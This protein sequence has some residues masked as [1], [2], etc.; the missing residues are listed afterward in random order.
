VSVG[1]A[2][3][4]VGVG[5]SVEGTGVSV[6]GTDVWVG[7]TVGAEVGMGV[8]VSVG[9]SVGELVGAGL[10]V[11]VGGRCVGVGEAV[12]S[13]DVGCAAMNAEVGET[14]LGGDAASLQPSNSNITNDRPNTR[15]RYILGYICLL[16]HRFSRHSHANSTLRRSA[17]EYIT[18]DVQ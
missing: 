13:L 8:D 4:K 1:G 2:G 16:T 9:V 10:G 3:E 11:S 5:V 15:S 18:A 14:E 17:T 6:G 7:V 12:A